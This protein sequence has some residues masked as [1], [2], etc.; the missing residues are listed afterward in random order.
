MNK[1]YEDFVEQF[2]IEIGE[3]QP[4]PKEETQEKPAKRR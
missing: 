2:L 3:K 4:P 1:E